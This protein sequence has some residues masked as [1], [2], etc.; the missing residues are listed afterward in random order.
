M[1]YNIQNTISYT[2]FFLYFSSIHI[3]PD[4]NEDYDYI[5]QSDLQ[6]YWS[7]N[8]LISDEFFDNS[9]YSYINLINYR[10]LL[11]S[12]YYKS[13]ISLKEMYKLR[14]CLIDFIDIR[15]IHSV[16]EITDKYY[17][18]QMKYLNCYFVKRSGRFE[19]ICKIKPEYKKLI[20]DIKKHFEDYLID[21]NYMRSLFS[22][23]SIIF[24]LAN[25]YTY[26]D[27]LKIILNRMK[28]DNAVVTIEHIANEI[29]RTYSYSRSFKN[30]DNIKTIKNE[31]KKYNK[32]K[33]NNQG[34]VTF[35]REN[36]S[37]LSWITNNKCNEFN[38]P[39]EDI[40]IDS[41]SYTID[42]NTLINAHRSPEKHIRLMQICKTE[43]ASG[44]DIIFFRTELKYFRDF[45][46]DFFRQSIVNENYQIIEMIRNAG[47]NP[48]MDIAN[49]TFVTDIMKN[50]KI[51]FIFKFIQ[52][53]YKLNFLL[54]SKYIF[55]CDTLLDYS[56]PNYDSIQIL[57]KRF[58]NELPLDL[59][60]EKIY[61]LK[62]NIART[63]K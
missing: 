24:N 48:N 17:E 51:D 49:E 4:C 37:Y 45:F 58:K 53:G 8:E 40:D 25:N 3:P 55:L 20:T 60:A 32:L 44:S 46:G 43:S 39:E 13:N 18:T 50:Q 14:Y 11:H 1:E 34:E 41:I 7:Y 62:N 10:K 33:F 35:C 22:Q 59:R 19:N 38:L 28:L 47:Y 16:I 61:K 52:Y 21:P 6:S 31:I 5:E 30:M 2:D 9:N 27:T 42:N 54:K 26:E 63:I 12:L 29:T 56:S 15:F 36:S 23:L 57:I